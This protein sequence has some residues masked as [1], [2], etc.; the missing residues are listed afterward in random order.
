MAQRLYISDFQAN[1]LVEGVFA[2][3]NCQL[4]L[5]RNGKPF[6]KCLIADKTNRLPG[7]MWNASEDLFN[8]L[9]TNGFVRIS[10]QT[11]PYQ[12]ELQVIIRS[13]AAVEPTIDDLRELIPSTD[14]DVEAM[15]AEVV[16]IVQSVEHPALKALIQAY[17][18]DAELM[19]QFRSAPAA[20]VL[21]HAYLGGLLEHTE[22]LLKLAE[23]VVPHYPELNR[24]VVITG[25][26]LH[27]LGKCAEL[28]WG[29][30][31]DYTDEGRLVGH[32]ARGVLWLERKAEQVAAAGTPL[33]PGGL[34]ILQHII[35]SHHGQPE[36]GALKIP[37][38]PEAIFIHN[39]DNLDAKMQMSISAVRGE[40]P[41][42]AQRGGRFTEK[43]WA[44][45]TRLYRPDPFAK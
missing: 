22:S 38:T 19:D 39:I 1:Q 3:Q 15:F 12:G 16:R 26:F 31:F 43:I 42:A 5:T 9:P 8:E 36:F 18:D 33:P 25:L 17:L 30:G 35:L 7:R 41:G 45:D 4:G 21:H 40:Q 32:I 13:I 28:S 29:S 6:L 10:G 34:E 27:D 2:I 37:S 14:R 11:Q 23:Q 20:M 44:L 24:D